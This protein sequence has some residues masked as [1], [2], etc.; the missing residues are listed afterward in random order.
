[1]YFFISKR[2]IF[3]ICVVLSIPFNSLS[4]VL[5]FI[6]GGVNGA[7]VSGVAGSV[8]AIYQWPNV[9]TDGGVTIKAKIEIISKSGTATLTTIDGAS[10]AADWEPQ[11]GGPALT[12]GNSWGIRFQVRFYNA[13]TNAAYSISSFV[14]QG[15]DIDGGGAGALP[16]REYCTFTSADSYTLETPTDLTVSSVA[17]GRKFRSSSNLYNGISILQTQYITS[18]VYTNVNNFYITCGVEA[19]AGNVAAGSR[20]FSINFRNVVVFVTPVVHLPINLISFS[21]NKL[22]NEQIEL[23]WS[24][25]TEINNDYFVIERLIDESNYFRVDS[26]KGA[27]TSTIQNNYIYLDRSKDEILYYRLRQ[28]DYNGKSSYSDIISIDARIP[29]R[30]ISYKVNIMGEEVNDFYR[31]LVIIVYSDGSSLKIIQ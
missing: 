13:A 20:L 9:G 19:V 15:I 31:G 14:A 4:V 16:L 10:T 17:D 18:N 1:M 22:E 26:L 2:S 6:N 7:L 24:T 3:V 12:T 30:E 23:D 29:K 28:V 21:G 25:A 27:G 11:V 8:G 5:Q